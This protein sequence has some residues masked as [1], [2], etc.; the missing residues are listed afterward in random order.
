MLRQRRFDGIE[1]VLAGEQVEERIRVA[2][3]DMLLDKPL[4]LQC[5]DVLLACIGAGSLGEGWA[6]RNSNLSSIELACCYSH[7]TTSFGVK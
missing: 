4:L 7:I 3:T 6:F 5:A 2:V 1:Q